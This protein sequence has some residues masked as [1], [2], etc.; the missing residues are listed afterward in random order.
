M[1]CDDITPLLEANFD[2]ELD[3]V[4]QLEV[5]AH[6]RA[7]PGCASRAKAIEARRDALR[8]SIPRFAA[9]PQLRER[10]HALLQAERAPAALKP[11]GRP[12]LPWRFW[13]L[14]G[15]A[16]SLALALIVGYASGNRRSRAN[17]LSNEAISDHVRSLQAAHL[18]DVASTDQH[19]VK[20]WF[21]GKLDFSPPVFDLADVGFPLA[22][23][24]LEHID[25]RPAAALVFHRRLHIINLFVWPA[26]NGALT[27]RRG[28]NNGYYTASWSA[29]GLNFLAVSEISAAELGQFE[30][31]YRKRAN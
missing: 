18:M 23:G 22:G 13:N 28:G 7:C 10:I 15:L 12:S 5:E 27:E 20:P 30:S 6:L 1:K 21:A 25:D 17:S 29:G 26:T 11:S 8:N 24:R 2:G 4:R 19:T 3:L 9:P 14:T 16:A 31:E